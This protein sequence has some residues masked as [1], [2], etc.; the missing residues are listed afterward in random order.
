MEGA[1]LEKS[2]INISANYTVPMLLVLLLAHIMVGP[3]HNLALFYDEAYYHFWSTQL[4]FGYYSKPPM[5]AW[6]IAA[7]TSI[8]GHAEW[9]VRL[10]SALLYFCTA[11]VIRQIAMR[12]WQRTDVADSAA[13]LFFTAPLIGFNS[14]FVTTDAPLLFFWSVAVWSFVEALKTRK[15][16]YWVSLGVALG[17]GMLSK[18][19]MCVLMIGLFAYIGLDKAERKSE[20]TLGLLLAVLIALVLFLP[21]LLWN[22]AH[23]FI[24][25][26][27]TA[28]ISKLNQSLLH[29]L[30][31]LE[32]TA[33]Q[34][35]AF[36]PVAFWVLTVWVW[37]QKLSA[38]TLLLMCVT[39]PMLLAMMVQALLSHAN[40]NWAAPTYVGGSLLA[41]YWLVERGKFAV[42]KAAMLVNVL[43]IG[44]F[45]SY[46]QIQSA[47]D[48]EPTKKNTP[49]QRV[50]GW[51]ELVLAIPEQPQDMVYLS[52]SR[53]LLSYVHFYRSDFT[54]GS[55]IQVR[56]FNPSGIIKDHYQLNY[57]L[58]AQY[59]EHYLFL[60][61]TPKALHGCFQQVQALEPVSVD[62][63]P[64]LT[65]KL[66][67]YQ[68]SG[69]NGYDGC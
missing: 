37:R 49:Y 7:T 11:L 52:D 69:F 9:A 12:L 8:F 38:T 27:H 43:L 46:P 60:S 3:F 15:W 2:G 65:R 55:G 32:F 53:A 1:A 39:F 42:L 25:F 34:V 20:N 66:Y 30:R 21:N 23:D 54:Q 13:I 51:R 56:S 5:I 68:V 45:Y 6:L 35:F 48:I 50:S 22:A 62:V 40:A 18:Y 67:L 61:E 26:Q 58:T 10:S 17:L 33:G 63:Y 4:D 59:N 57:P 29:P 64:T 36:G 14:L 16:I 28:E 41:A 19:T 44:L 24:S 31:W 47:L